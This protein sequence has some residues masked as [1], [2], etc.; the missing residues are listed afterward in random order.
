MRQISLDRGKKAENRA[1]EDQREDQECTKRRQ[2]TECTGANRNG[3]NGLLQ[4][5]TKAGRGKDEKWY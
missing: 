5:D 2:E 4:T 1:K 3:S